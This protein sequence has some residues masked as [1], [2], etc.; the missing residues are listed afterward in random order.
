ML[1]PLIAARRSHRRYN[2][3]TKT[4][5][6][7]A[8]GYLPRTPPAVAVCVPIFHS[9]Y[10]RCLVFDLDAKSRA[11]AA[12]V[13]ADYARLTAWISAAGGRYISD[14][15][16]TSAGRH[17]YVP[18]PAGVAI[19]RGDIETLM[20]LLARLLPSLDISPMLNPSTGA[21]APPGSTSKQGGI[22]MLDGTLG[23][24]VEAFTT[25]S[26][27]GF[28]ARLTTSLGITGMPPATKGPTAPRPGSD[29]NMLDTRWWAG[30][31]DNT[32]LRSEFRWSTH[33]PTT[34]TNYAQTG[35]RP[36]NRRW[37]THSEARQSVLAHCAVRGWSLAEVRAQLPQRGGD[38]TGLS[39][40]Y[41]RYQRN[42]DSQ[43]RADWSKACYWA[44]RI[45][46]EVRASAHKFP[47]HTGGWAPRTTTTRHARWLAASTAWVDQQW[48]NAARRWTVLAVLQ[49]LSYASATTGTLVNDT[50][51]AEI[52]VRSLS[53]MAGLLSETTVAAI[54]RQLRDTPGA[55]I[56]RVRRAAGRLAD[57]YA[58]TTPVNAQG[59]PYV[60]DE[61]ATR[62][63]QVAPIHAA[64]NV[65]GLRG[66]RVF[67]LVAFSGLERI[68]DIR[69]ATHMS[70]SACYDTTL[71]LIVTGLLTRERGRLRRGTVSLDEIAHA[72]GLPDRQKTRIARHRIERHQWWTWLQARFD[73]QWTPDPTPAE[74]P[75]SL[76]PPWED[77]DWAQ[78]CDAVAHA[79]PPD[80]HLHHYAAAT[81]VLT[82][83]LEAEQVH[84][85][86]RYRRHTPDQHRPPGP[87]RPQ[88]PPN[89]VSRQ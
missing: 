76:A 27:R 20:R 3:A 62:R 68:E 16:T 24:A 40:A 64:W 56:L 19:R 11:S 86:P 39:A 22:R 25:R 79:G 10:A 44:S 36:A 17:I 54:L 51:V 18:L 66:R 5:D 73:Q 67:E 71:S 29:T 35:T 78:W 48:P 15:S 82:D 49:A 45:T 26:D 31:G 59:K 4:Y 57:R 60:V 69:A 12:Q 72:H 37:P 55:P 2:L 6:N 47:Q 58:L 87:P 38:W 88:Q 1:T 84:T 50:P 42:T 33:L 81:H 80:E 83:H 41:N 61:T 13:A 89:K 34:I 65:L 28:L 21:I 7:R 30:S 63:I 23:D 32:R 53:I 77:A 75:R 14:T 85:P 70:R 43:L 9:G 8:R 46:E 74:L 52:G